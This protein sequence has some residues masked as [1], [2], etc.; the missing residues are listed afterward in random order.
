MHQTGPFADQLRAMFDALGVDAAEDAFQKE[1]ISALLGP[2]FDRS[3]PL[4]LAAMNVR[5][6]TLVLFTSDRGLCGAFNANA[7][8]AAHQWL[9]KQERNGVESELVCVGRRGARHFAKT[10]WT[11]IRTFEALDAGFNPQLYWDGYR[12]WR[13]RGEAPP[14]PAALLS[15][16]SGE[17]DPRL[18]IGY[19]RMLRLFEL[20]DYLVQRFAN[21]LS[22]ETFADGTNEIA[23]SYTHYVSPAKSVATTIPFL[24]IK[25]PAVGGAAGRVNHIFEP[26]VRSLLTAFMPLYA[27]LTIWAAAA[28][29]QASEQAMRVV[30]MTMA[31]DLAEQL[32]RSLTLSYNKARQAAITKEILE[33]NT[34]AEA[35]RG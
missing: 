15:R 26:D 32:I 22:Q 35:L 7:I 29:T 6:R 28:H 19:T 12:K 2:G 23:L 10:D 33:V 18:I 25:P 13:D 16:W 11:V 14:A 9:E 30:A 21:G 1:M 17:S 4:D 34:G 3:T 8:N 31:T 27:D 24:S 20:R 5:R